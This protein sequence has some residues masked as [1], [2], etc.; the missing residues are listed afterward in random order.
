MDWK[1]CIR[2]DCY[3]AVAENLDKMKVKLSE[4]SLAKRNFLRFAWSDWWLFHHHFPLENDE[5]KQSPHNKS[6]ALRN[7]VP[8]V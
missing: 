6:D 3:A 4:P 5:K 8:F 1:V 2:D 7:F